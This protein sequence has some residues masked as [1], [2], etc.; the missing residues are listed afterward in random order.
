MRITTIVVND[1]TKGYLKE[2][3]KRY[4]K[5]YDKITWEQFMY[6]MTITLQE[7]LKLGGDAFLNTMQDYYSRLYLW[8]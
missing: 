7:E 3:K 5:K 4:E 1:L 8:R 2:I 6:L